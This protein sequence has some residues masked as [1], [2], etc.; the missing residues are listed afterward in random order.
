MQ[1][2]KDHIHFDGISAQDLAKE[3]GT[4]TYVYEGTRIRENYRR[5]FNAFQSKWPRFKI[6]YA[7]KSNSNPAIIKLLMEEG[8]GCDCA[9]ANEILLA[10][11]LGAKG[12][13]ILFS[14]NYLNDV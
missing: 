12:E 1:I 13:Q 7:V 10:Q 11:K 5:L 8:A 6:Y 9:S 14:G 4:P 3:F 2:I